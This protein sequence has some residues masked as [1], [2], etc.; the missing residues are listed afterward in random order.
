M[1]PNS[2]N[3]CKLFY[4]YDHVENDT[5]LG[6]P[7]QFWVD[8]S[9]LGKLEFAVTTSAD[10]TDKSKYVDSCY[11]TIRDSKG[12]IMIAEDNMYRLDE[13]EVY[14]LEFTS[15]Y[16]NGIK[17]GSRMLYL[18]SHMPRIDDIEGMYIVRRTSFAQH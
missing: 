11:I 5:R 12:Q 10:G 8:K 9:N 16:L 4:A 15:S 14:T 13:D 2:Q 18:Y 17:T 7:I 3:I 6:E 1:D